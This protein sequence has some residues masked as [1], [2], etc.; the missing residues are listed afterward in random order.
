MQI[1]LC[2]CGAIGSSRRPYVARGI[3]R[4]ATFRS[5][6]DKFRQQRLLAT[7]FDDVEAET[8]NESA[9]K[10]VADD[11]SPRKNI[12][13]KS[14]SEAI[15]AGLEMYK[16]EK[17][18]AA[19]DVFSD[20]LE[21]P[22][23]GVVRMGGRCKEYSCPSEGEENAALYNMTCCYAKLGQ[24]EGG[25][26]C[27]EGLLENGFEDFEQIAKDSDLDGLRGAQFNEIVGKY[28]TIG[29]K[30]SKMMGSKKKVN[31]DKPWLTW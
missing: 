20:S 12:P 15:N 4:G 31:S 3:Q 24:M 14:C 8:T 13:Y 5:R 11:T 18:Q 19:L 25:L 6:L 26:V 29:S 9:V 17:Y 16:N 21:L 22:G 30:V 10:N 7:E 27:L 28:D 23:K 2:S 1:A